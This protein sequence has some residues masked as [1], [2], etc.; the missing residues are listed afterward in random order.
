MMTGVCS[1]SARSSASAEKSKHSFGRRRNQHH[2]L[3]VAVRCV[4]R[5]HQVSLLRARRHARRRTGALH[6]D[7][8]RRNLGEI[9]ETEELAHQ[10]KARTTRCGERAR[11]VPCR[12]DDH[13][14]GSEFIFRLHDR[15]FFLAGCFVD[16]EAVRVALERLGHRRRRRDR[17]PRAHRRAAVHG[18]ERGRG[19]A[20]DHDPLANGVATAQLDRQRLVEVVARIIAADFQRVH[21]RLDQRVLAFVL[22]RHHAGEHVEIDADQR[23]QRTHI[24]DVLEQLPLFRILEFRQQ[25]RR[26]RD[27]D[28]D[29]VAA[30]EFPRPRP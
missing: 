23:G 21:V 19:V 18:A 13:A 28:V 4:H 17:I 9:R 20:F 30:R 26:D 5:R 11:A 24:H 7:Q 8:H 10:R 29:D 16:A 1:R 12:A 2:V 15:E 25:Q 22:L 3:R 27:A 14:D 6:I